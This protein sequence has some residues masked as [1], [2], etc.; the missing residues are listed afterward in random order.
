MDLSSKI[1]FEKKTLIL[2]VTVGKIPKYT[3][4]IFYCEK[5]KIPSIII[6]FP[7]VCLV[8]ILTGQ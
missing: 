4:Y 1:S 8:A 2:Q 6:I 3:I 5:K 7:D